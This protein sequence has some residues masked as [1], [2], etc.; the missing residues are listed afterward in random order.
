VVSDAAVRRRRRELCMWRCGG[1][2]EKSVVV[3]DAAVG[4]RKVQRQV[5]LQWGG[6]KCSGK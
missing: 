6:E 4:R 2:E 1:A 3:S 5:M